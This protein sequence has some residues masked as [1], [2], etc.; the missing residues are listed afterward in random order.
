MHNSFIKVYITTVFWVI[1]T[2]CNSSFSFY[3]LQY[4]NLISW[5]ILYLVAALI[6]YILYLVALTKYILYLVAALTK[7]RINQEIKFLYCKK[8]KLN[9]LLYRV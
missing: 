3:F 9:E 2:P 7:Y 8:H 5:F 1:C 4:K 6:K